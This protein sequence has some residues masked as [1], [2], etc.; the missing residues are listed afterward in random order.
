MY[1]NGVFIIAE[2]AQAHDGSLG[3][4]HSFIDALKDT[5][6]DAVKFQVHIA[7]AES[8]IFEK[9]RIEFSYEDAT[10]FDYWKR[11]EF[12]PD[13]WSGLKKHCE[14]CGMEFMASVFS[15]AAVD[16]LEKL[17]VKRYKVGSGETSNLLMLNKIANTGK[18]VILSS[19]MSSYEELDKVVDLLKVRNSEVSI[20][21]CT[22]SYPTEPEQWGL[23][24]IKEL[25]DR[26]QVPIGFSDHSG[27]IYACLAATALGAEIIEFH[28]TFDKKMFGP[29]TTASLTISQVKQAVEGIRQIRKSLL[30]PIDK[31]D[32][33]GLTGLKNIFEKSLAVNQHL[34]AG[35][36]LTEEMLEAKKPKGFG[37]NASEFS[38]VI[39]RK[40]K[41]ELKAWDFLTYNDLL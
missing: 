19:G 36:I 7:D 22:T 1:N 30:N 41:N 29:D 31:N 24:L 5:C 37:I 18:P 16:L 17:E 14:D 33:K 32:I 25:R 26:Y 35:T 34:K 6:V 12:T 10:R 40:L 38:K 11:M 4:A 9:F 28:V 39:G 23:N 15:N 8:S 3:I 13:Q 21:Q 2:I 27:E 20:L